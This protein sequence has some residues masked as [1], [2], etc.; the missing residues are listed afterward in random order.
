MFK[1]LVSFFVRLAKKIMKLRRISWNSHLVLQEK[2]SAPPVAS[3]PKKGSVK[4]KTAPEESK[5]K[6]TSEIVKEEKEEMKKK[7][8][9]VEDAESTVKVCLLIT[10]TLIGRR[11]IFGLHPLCLKCE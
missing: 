4:D 8:S 10:R 3:K 2:T 6:Q 1:A 5:V 7:E 9:D 11:E